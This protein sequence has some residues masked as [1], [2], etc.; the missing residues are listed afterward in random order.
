MGQV[1]GVPREV[2]PGEKRVATVPDVVPKLAKLGFSVIVQSGAGE[3][4]S[5]GDAA[6]AAAGATVVPTPRPSGPAPTSSSR[7]RARRD[8]VQ[9]MREGQ[10]L[11]SFIWPAQN[12]DL[13]QSL[14][15]EEGHRPRRWTACRASRGRRS[16]TRSRRWRTSAATAR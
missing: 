4:A 10:V 2:F 13:L 3:A 12:P 5:I 15:G 1:I 6:Y 8:E 7:S 14:A 11:V 9:A 16:W